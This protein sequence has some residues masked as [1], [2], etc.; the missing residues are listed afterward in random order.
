MTN[1]LRAHGLAVT[2]PTG[3]DGA[4]TRTLGA[5]PGEPGGPGDG[6]TAH[7]VVH[8]ATFALP[9]V[10]GD[11]GGGAVESMRA[12]DVFI[13]LVEFDPEAG[14]TPLF[15]DEGVQPLLPGGFRRETM[16]RTIPGQ[17]GHQQF[18]H[19]NGRAFCLYV[20]IGS[21]ARRARLARAAASVVST[22]RI[23]PL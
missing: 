6:G 16:H 4:I 11:Y 9:R 17:A 20:A 3:W 10:R 19:A 13:T 1:R 12:D 2:V 5:L 18:F 21:H 23:D 8:V 7:P 15:V 14:D 22:L